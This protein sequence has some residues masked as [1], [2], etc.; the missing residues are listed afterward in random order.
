MICVAIGTMGN[1][2]ASSHFGVTVVKLLHDELSLA[3]ISGDTRERPAADKT[4][5]TIRCYICLSF[6]VMAVASVMWEDV[7]GIHIHL[8]LLHACR[9]LN[10]I[11]SFDLI[12]RVP[13]HC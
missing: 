6:T 12:C 4:K 2:Q 1:D 9:A 13:H 7:M 3:L 10:L 5:S 11:A 8:W